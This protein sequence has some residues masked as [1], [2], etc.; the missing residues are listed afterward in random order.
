VNG[1]AEMWK[2]LGQEWCWPKEQSKHDNSM[3]VVVN[4]GGDGFIREELVLCEARQNMKTGEIKRI[5]VDK[6]NDA[7]E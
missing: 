6:L 2:S 7:D 5:P 1:M 4:I 3:I